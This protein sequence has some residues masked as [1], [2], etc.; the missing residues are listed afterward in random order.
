MENTYITLEDIKKTKINIKKSVF[1][2]E[3]LEVQ[4]HQQAMDFVGLIKNKYPD[5]NHHCWAYIIDKNMLSDDNG[6]PHGTAG[7]P[8]LNVI[9]RKQ[10]NNLVIVVIRYFGGKKLGVR[11]LINAYRLV[12]ENFIKEAITVT[13]NSGFMYEIICNFN[14]ANKL[15][16]SHDKKFKIIKQEFSDTVMMTIFIQSDVIS[17]YEEE[18]KSNNIKIVSKNESVK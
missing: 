18:F 13:R 5:A 16:V 17:Y 11:G 2:S 15:S 4:N 3:G 14:Y 1:I 9:K 12:T 7:I 6:K 8:I 10:L